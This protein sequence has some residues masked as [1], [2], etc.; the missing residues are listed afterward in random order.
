MQCANLLLFQ[1]ERAN[2]V[3]AVVVVVVERNCIC[4]YCC[5]YCC[6]S[7]LSCSRVSGLFVCLLCLCCDGMN[8]V[9]TATVVVDGVVDGVWSG[10]KCEW[11]SEWVSVV[12]LL[13]GMLQWLLLIFKLKRMWNA[14]EI[15]DRV[16]CFCC[17]CCWWWWCCECE[18]QTHK[19]CKTL[20]QQQQQLQQQW[21]RNCS[22][23]S[24]KNKFKFTISDNRNTVSVT[25]DNVVV[26][27][28]FQRQIQQLQNSIANTAMT[29][30]YIHCKHYNKNTKEK[31]IIGKFG[32]ALIL[33]NT[34]TQTQTH[35]ISL[36][37]KLIHSL[38]RFCCRCDC[39]C[40]WA[41]FV[42]V[43][44]LWVFCSMLLRLFVTFLCFVFVYL[45]MGCVVCVVTV[46]VFG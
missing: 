1:W 34:Q 44:S 25:A 21:K 42:Y 24:N 3:V 18:R 19:N 23:D 12:L 26:V 40:V 33:T 16:C 31:K 37:C 10:S 39:S 22:W 17:C 36:F 6:V 7:F 43:S 8:D 35:I 15:T 14:L 29:I 13:K 30:Y 5:C 32:E 45:L 28:L 20:Q 11:V 41:V 38:I 27:E 46:F 2:S 4:C 9:A